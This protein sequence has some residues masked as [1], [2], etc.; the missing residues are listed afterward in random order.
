LFCYPGNSSNQ[1]S[2]MI[3]LGALEFLEYSQGFTKSL[4]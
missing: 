3:L 2:L 4:Y 1:P